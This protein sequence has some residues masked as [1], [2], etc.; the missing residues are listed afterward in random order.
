MRRSHYAYIFVPVVM[1]GLWAAF[2]LPWKARQPP[3]RQVNYEAMRALWIP[4]RE[5]A[6]EITHRSR[7]A[8][9]R[10]ELDRILS[11]VYRNESGVPR[12]MPA[13]PAA[14]PPDWPAGERR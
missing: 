6:E 3:P 7:M 10:H 4:P 12:T 2:Y 5:S 9:P 13:P 8:D 1:T 14:R 11:S